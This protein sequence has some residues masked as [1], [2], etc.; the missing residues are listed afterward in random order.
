[1][2]TAEEKCCFRL[3]VRRSDFFSFWILGLGTVYWVIVGS[4]SVGEFELD[5]FRADMSISIVRSEFGALGFWFVAYEYCTTTW[6]QFDRNSRTYQ[7]LD[8]H[9]SSDEN[10]NS[11]WTLIFPV[12]ACAF[13]NR[14]Q[15][16]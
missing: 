15:R 4:R 1:M 10:R 9:K 12:I 11:E 5:A 13:V 2:C 6:W 3:G 16:P 8:V 14:H 7:A